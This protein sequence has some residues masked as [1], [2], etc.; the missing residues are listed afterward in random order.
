[1]GIKALVVTDVIRSV[2]S[3]DDGESIIEQAYIS[4]CRICRK[5]I[6]G[7]RDIETNRIYKSKSVV[8]TDRIDKTS[9]V[10]LKNYYSSKNY[11]YENNEKVHKKV[12][13]LRKAGI[14]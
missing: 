9:V 11:Q 5:T 6:I 2:S 4:E 7:Y 12:M 10:P 14:L 3:I 13:R 8:G 1:M